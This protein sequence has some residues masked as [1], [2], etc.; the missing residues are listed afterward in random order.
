MSSCGT[1]HPVRVD[2]YNSNPGTE[3]SWLYWISGTES[4]RYGWFTIEAK[5][6][7]LIF[8][9]QEHLPSRYILSSMARRR[10]KDKVKPH[11]KETEKAAVET[12]HP[13]H[14]EMETEV[15]RNRRRRSERY[16]IQD[17]RSKGA[18][19][20]GAQ[21]GM[22]QASATNS[23]AQDRRRGGRITPEEDVTTAKPQPQI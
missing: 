2:Y 7:N 13:L 6:N 5:P 9:C 1:Q 21:K 4:T 8:L 23:H 17:W 3:W 22:R 11:Q 16:T 12:P 20:D 14:P 15:R 10:K 18:T 19:R